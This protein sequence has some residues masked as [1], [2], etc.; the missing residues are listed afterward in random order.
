M[1]N[2]SH[3]IYLIGFDQ[4]SYDNV[5]DRSEIYHHFELS[6]LDSNACLQMLCIR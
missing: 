6:T 4:Y 1:N 5:T 2:K 3:I